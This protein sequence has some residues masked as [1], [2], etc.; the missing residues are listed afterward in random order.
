LNNT[1]A[2]YDELA[3]GRRKLSTIFGSS[4]PRTINAGGILAAAGA[5]GIYQLRTGW[6]CQFRE[7]GNDGRSIVDVYLP[8]D[9]IGLDTILGTRRLEELLTLTAL[10]IEEIPAE[11]A[12]MK[13]MADRPTALYIAWLLGQRQRRTDR[14][15][16]A[17]SCLDAR[18]RLAMLLLDFY[19]RL[20]RRRLISGSIYD[21]PLTQI[22]I[23]QYL[24]LTVMHINRV[25]RAL[26][27]EQIVNL[28]KHCVTIL[29]L[30][31]L[32]ILARYG[33]IRS[34]SGSGGERGSKEAA[35]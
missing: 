11:D 16:A 32:A 22:Q 18:G 33:G 29:D 3:L 26:R 7:F 20:R 15:R 5:S 12:L 6:A 10:T 2:L 9:M 23:G 27:D 19:K 24:G 34:L 8:G 30:N 21:L 1:V 25:L 13:L 35:D 4:L 28:E 31:R 14:L 17:I